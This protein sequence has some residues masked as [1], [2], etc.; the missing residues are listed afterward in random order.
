MFNLFAQKGKQV[1]VGYPIEQY[2]NQVLK[3]VYFYIFLLPV[4][5]TYL[6]KFVGFESN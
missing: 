5:P 1:Y 2:E 4:I 6:R 3:I